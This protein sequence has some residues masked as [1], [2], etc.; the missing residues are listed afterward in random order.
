MK[1]DTLLTWIFSI[2]LSL[3]I[4]SEIGTQSCPE[5]NETNTQ[6]SYDLGYFHGVSHTNSQN[7]TQVNKTIDICEE[8]YNNNLSRERCY[9][10][11][12]KIVK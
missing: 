8:D 1:I 11:W 2:V 4:G 7:W 6:D 5:C 10:E 3:L 12:A 9:E